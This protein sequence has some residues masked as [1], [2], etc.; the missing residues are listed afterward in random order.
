MT[1]RWINLG[2]FRSS[3]E[4]LV[5]EPD[6][7][8]TK[9]VGKVVFSNRTKRTR[10]GNAY[11]ACAARIVVGNYELQ[12]DPDGKVRVEKTTS[13]GEVPYAKRLRDYGVDSETVKAIQEKIDPWLEE[14]RKRYGGQ[15]Q[16]FR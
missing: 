9:L 6:D 14:Q 7:D 4:G 8:G 16:L 12:I 15:R 2:R 10:A 3:I 5:E 13:E 11:R 1:A